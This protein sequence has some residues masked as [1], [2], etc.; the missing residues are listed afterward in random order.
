[1]VN[2]FVAY[3]ILEELFEQYCGEGREGNLFCLPSRD[4]EGVVKMLENAVTAYGNLR[5]FHNEVRYCALNLCALSKFGTLE[6]RTMRGADNAK[7]VIDWIDILKQLD[8]FCSN[9]ME[10]P[11]KLVES[12]SLLGTDG[13]LHQ[14]FD[15]ATVRKLLASWP[16]DRPLAYSLMEGARLVQVL[17]YRL[18]EAYRSPFVQPKEKP[19]QPVRKLQQGNV[20]GRYLNDIPHQR[21]RTGPG[22]HWYIPNTR[23]IHMERITGAE[24][25]HWDEDQEVWVETRTGHV[26]QWRY[27]NPDI[28]GVA[29]VWAGPEIGARQM[30]VDTNMPIGEMSG[31][32]RNTGEGI[33]VHQ[34]DGRIFKTLD[35][36]D[37]AEGR[38]NDVEPDIAE[39]DPDLDDWDPEDDVNDEF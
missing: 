39:D 16:A 24:E 5:D 1:V 8:N 31:N 37:R 12:L 38:I 27:L 13:F 22:G 19:P 7:Q 20:R 6:I 25:F 28:V 33:W 29:R 11:V 4:V 2:F 35:A 9:K 17:A 10:T 23:P 30:L 34:F 21:V 15:P 32:L 18:D 26:M 14:I 3:T 36:W